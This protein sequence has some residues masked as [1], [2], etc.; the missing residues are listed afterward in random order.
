MAKQ[1]VL[2]LA[3]VFVCT[4]AWVSAPLAIAQCNDLDADGF[5]SADGCGSARDC[6]DANPWT[7][8]GALEFLDGYDNDCNGYIDDMAG[9]PPPMCEAPGMVG[10]GARVT[11][12]PE[13]SVGATVAWNSVEREYGV[14]W[15]DFR[16]GNWDIYFSRLDEF[17][18][19]IGEIEPVTTDPGNSFAQSLVWTGSDYG[20][21]WYDDRGEDWAIYFA[22][23]DGGGERIGGDQPIT[24]EDAVAYSPALVWNGSGYGVAWADAR[25]EGG[26]EIY[27]ALLDASGSKLGDD[28]RVTDSPGNSWLPTIAFNSSDQEY[29]IAW[30][31]ERDQDEDENREIY[32]TRLDSSGARLDE[33][34]FRVTQNPEISTVPSLVWTGSQYAMAWSDSQTGNEE[35]FLARLDPSGAPFGTCVLVERPA[36]S[37][38]DEC[39]SDPD[40]PTVRGCSAD[41]PPPWPGFPCSQD[42]QC[43][44]GTCVDLEQACIAA[45]QVTKNA[46]QSTTPSLSWTG[47]EFGLVWRDDR[48]DMQELYF[49]SVDSSGELIG[50]CESVEVPLS[51]SFAPCVGSCPPAKGCNDT[52]DL[53][54]GTPCT[55]HSDCPP[56]SS[57]TGLCLNF[58]QWCNGVRLTTSPLACADDPSVT[59]T[60]DEACVFA[61]LLG[62]CNVD[63]GTMS[64]GPSTTVWNGMG[65]GVAWS[66]TRD[67]NEEIYLG[68]VDCDCADSDEDRFMSCQDCDDLNSAVYPGHPETCG[69]DVINDCRSWGIDF[70]DTDGDGTVDPDDC[71]TDTDEDEFGNPGFLENECSEDNCPD[72][73]NPDQIDTDGSGVGDACNPDNDGDGILDD[74]SQS[75]VEGDLRCPIFDTC[76]TVGVP[77]LCEDSGLPCVNNAD[78]RAYCDDNCIVNANTDQSDSDGDKSGDVCDNCPDLHN[79]TQLDSDEDGKGNVCDN[80]PYEPNNQLDTDL[81]GVGDPCDNCP[82]DY[83]PDQ[84][85]TDDDGLGDACDDDDDGD[86]VADDDDNCPVDHNEQQ[87]DMDGDLIGDH[88]D[89]D[90]GVIYLVFPDTA[91]VDWQSE[92][93]DSW[94]G[95]TGNLE[96]LRATGDYTQA[97]NCGLAD[98]GMPHTDSPAPG[99]VVFFLATGVSA[100][101]EGGLGNDS[102]GQPRPNGGDCN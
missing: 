101:N 96:T 83:N 80:C 9:E 88:C 5:L 90:D 68:R 57:P 98:S 64:A 66:D 12:D 11:D 33:D 39:T 69:D 35:I 23:L 27:F 74:G 44:G 89:E 48:H 82:V 56:N 100:G 97:Q 65:F 75:G 16:N 40:C 30:Y 7:Y 28:I 86:N 51:S 53:P 31:D 17:G 36:S 10:E 47:S 79:F 59:C 15:Y 21:A 85:D 32:F 91:I 13:S 73:Y 52:S 3:F 24:D 71:C 18:E 26:S 50:L 46:A 38:G 49:V 63:T 34:D 58:E 102:E 84:R 60:S 95:Y 43:Q 72:T 99:E 55:S 93:F 4:V 92:G 20:L 67:G 81:D 61:G 62:P 8:P 14:A 78:C 37:T 70:P 76:D 77:H 87:G 25:H 29:G 42:F 41:S 54:L 19:M 22:R 6:N 94:N 2:A 45:S 1:R